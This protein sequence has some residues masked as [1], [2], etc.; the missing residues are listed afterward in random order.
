MRTLGS[1]GTWV[2]NVHINCPW[3]GREVQILLDIER[4]DIFARMDILDVPF[5]FVTKGIGCGV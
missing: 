3:Q 1:A 4:V 5:G 2:I